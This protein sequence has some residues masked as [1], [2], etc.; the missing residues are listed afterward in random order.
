MTPI[1]P[2]DPIVVA[3]TR[4]RITRE[5][6][7]LKLGEQAA[8]ALLWFNQYGLDQNVRDVVKVTASLVA[9]ATPKADV[10]GRYIAAAA[11]KFA[12]AIRDEAIRA[13]NADLEDS[14]RGEP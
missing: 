8:D 9:S 11:M 14:G 13:A 2:F 1:K 7:R 12:G 5:A 3:E 4:Q 10:A 6:N